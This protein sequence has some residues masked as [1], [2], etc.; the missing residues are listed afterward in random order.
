MLWLLLIL[1]ND[2]LWEI[3]LMFPHILMS[4]F[5]HIT[6]RYYWGLPKNTGS[7]FWVS[8][9]AEKFFMLALWTLRMIFI[10]GLGYWIDIWDYGSIVSEHISFSRMIPLLVVD[11][12]DSSFSLIC[13]IYRLCIIIWNANY[14]CSAGNWNILNGYEVDKVITLLIWDLYVLA[15]H[16]VCKG[17]SY[18]RTVI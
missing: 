13:S 2:I 12:C 16:S 10:L 4:N 9:C 7:L 5:L 3:F 11:F 8:F 14:L 15:Y 1:R 6:R 17:Y 18:L